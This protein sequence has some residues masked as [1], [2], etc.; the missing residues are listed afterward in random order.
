[1]SLATRNFISFFTATKM[2]QIPETPEWNQSLA[3]VALPFAIKEETISSDDEK[4]ANSQPP[5][6]KETSNK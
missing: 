5:Q 3:E 4:E 1:M 6:Q 2:D